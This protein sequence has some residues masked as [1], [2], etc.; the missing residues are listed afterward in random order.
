MFNFYPE[1]LTGRWRKICRKRG[2]CNIP[3][4]MYGWRNEGYC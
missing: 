1:N 2:S 3:I 4:E